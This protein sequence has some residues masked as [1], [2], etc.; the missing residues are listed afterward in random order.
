MTNKISVILIFF[1]LIGCASHQKLGT[2]IPGEISNKY[3]NSRIINK[4]FDQV[5]KDFIEVIGQKF[6]AIKNFEKD[7]GL[8]TLEFS[9][10]YTPSNY[11]NGGKFTATASERARWEQAFRAEDQNKLKDLY[12]LDNAD[13]FAKYDGGKLDGIANIVITEIDENK[14]KV[15]V[16]IR[17]IFTVPPGVNFSGLT[18]SFDSNECGV[19]FFTAVLGTETRTICSTNQAEM[20]ILDA[21]N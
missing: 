8:L 4:P 20:R 21:L 12:E 9:E 6:F 11:V 19:G 3:D 16:N 5:W 10:S 1:F 17:Y 14:V 2:Y 7:S 13:M 15:K 18:I